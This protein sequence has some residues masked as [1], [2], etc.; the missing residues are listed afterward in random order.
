[1]SSDELLEAHARG[2]GNWISTTA[3]SETRYRDWL[4]GIILGG[5]CLQD[6]T[7]AAQLADTVE[8]A[9]LIAEAVCLALGRHDARRIQESRRASHQQP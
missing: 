8:R 4:V 9:I 7:D 5:W 1:M 3:L 2:R 6:G